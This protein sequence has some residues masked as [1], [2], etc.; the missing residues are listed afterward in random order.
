MS[1]GPT[2]VS[3]RGGRG[4]FLS[5]RLVISGKALSQT[6]GH[7]DYRGRFDDRPTPKTGFKLVA[8]GRIADGIDDVRRAAREEIKGGADS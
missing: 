7:C 1:A 6:G 3:A 4:T 8:L 2:R 5:P